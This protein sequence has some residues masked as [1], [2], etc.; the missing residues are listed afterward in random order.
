MIGN[1]DPSGCRG[2]TPRVGV[3][4]N[5]FYK[6]L[7]L[8]RAM[9]DDGIYRVNT[10]SSFG[11]TK[12]SNGDETEEDVRD[13]EEAEARA[14][15]VRKTISGMILQNEMGGWLGTIGSPSLDYFFANPG[16]SETHQAQSD[17]WDSYVHSRQQVGWMLVEW[18][19]SLKP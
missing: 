3:N 2:S 11:W 18:V 13:E 10:S 6:E 8:V 19:Y 16:S 7:S 4:H 1:H 14:H 15:N 12:Y 5:N 17:L 9:G